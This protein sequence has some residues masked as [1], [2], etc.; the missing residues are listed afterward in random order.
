[1]PWELTPIVSILLLYDE[2]HAGAIKPGN[3]VHFL[4]LREAACAAP[5]GQWHG[6]HGEKLAGRSRPCEISREVT[7][8]N[9]E[10]LATRA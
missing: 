3:A 4:E 8:C 6:R 1:M 9:A 2:Y 10:I 7:L 5:H